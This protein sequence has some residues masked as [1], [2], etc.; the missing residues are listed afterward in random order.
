MLE[1][2]TPF[3]AG[4]LLPTEAN[5]VAILH[6]KHKHKIALDRDGAAGTAKERAFNPPCC[7]VLRP[8]YESAHQDEGLALPHQPA[9]PGKVVFAKA[10]CGR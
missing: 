9:I 8:P 3:R 1:K 4:H 6:R 10:R 5:L 7:F 2:S